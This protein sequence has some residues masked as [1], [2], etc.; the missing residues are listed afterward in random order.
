MSVYV[1]VHNERE[2]ERKREIERERLLLE[3]TS[4]Y[5]SI[6]D[7]LYCFEGILFSIVG[8]IRTDTRT[9]QVMYVYTC[10]VCITYVCTHNDN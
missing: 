6:V 2:R 5:E 10:T 8:H 7:C 9:L 1:C 4:I 3:V